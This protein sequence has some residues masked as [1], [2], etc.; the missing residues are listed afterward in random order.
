MA[1]WYQGALG[2]YVYYNSS[3]LIEDEKKRIKREQDEEKTSRTIAL[4]QRYINLRMRAL[5][6]KNLNKS[7]AVQEA[8]DA[9]SKNQIHETLWNNYNNDAY[10]KKAFI[11]AIRDN[12]GNNTIS[13][14]RLEQLLNFNTAT[15]TIVAQEQKAKNDFD[16]IK[17]T[18]IQTSMKKKII[19][20]LQQVQMKQLRKKT[21]VHLML[22]I[23]LIQIIIQ[24]QAI[25]HQVKVV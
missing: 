20:I 6:N 17:L 25:I 14:Q 23:I 22:T 10:T 9:M 16:K 4:Y 7:E 24:A 1:N 19:Q 2:Y 8:F 15:Q 13:E 5:K 21:M 18:K 3:T 11:Q 12:V